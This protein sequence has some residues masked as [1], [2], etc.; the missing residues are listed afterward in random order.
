LS[1]WN[2]IHYYLR[3]I[4]GFVVDKAISREI[5]AEFKNRTNEIDRG[6]NSAEALLREIANSYNLERV[7][8]PEEH[9]SRRLENL[10]GE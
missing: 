6:K 2:T 9:S 7:D 10:A 4:E 8:I 3:E 1:G 5:S